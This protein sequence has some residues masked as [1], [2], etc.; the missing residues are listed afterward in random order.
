MNK[1]TTSENVPTS[2]DPHE[3]IPDEF[4][5][6]DTDADSVQETLDNL[7]G[8]QEYQNEQRGDNLTYGDY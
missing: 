2:N 4:R 6:I 7:P 1:N 5:I 3:Q 8:F